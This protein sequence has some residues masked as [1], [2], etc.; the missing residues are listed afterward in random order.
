MKSSEPLLHLILFKQGLIL[1][2]L[3]QMKLSLSR[4]VSMSTVCMCTYKWI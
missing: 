1:L 4:T 3:N 2:L